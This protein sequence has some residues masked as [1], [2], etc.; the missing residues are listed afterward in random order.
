MFQQIC[1]SIYKFFQPVG[2]RNKS[3]YSQNDAKSL[4]NESLAGFFLILSICYKI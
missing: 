2:I 1:T 4:R 3:F